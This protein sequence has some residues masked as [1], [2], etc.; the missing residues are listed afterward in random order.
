MDAGQ[1]GGSVRPRLV[2]YRLTLL[3]GSVLIASAL[4]LLLGATG[5]LPTTQPWRIVVIPAYLVLMVSAVI[6]TAV[7]LAQHVPYVAGLVVAGVLVLGP[8]FAVDWFASRGRGHHRAA[9]A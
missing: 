2:D 9:D 8:F 1:A 5:V 4:V 6:R 7:P 3:A